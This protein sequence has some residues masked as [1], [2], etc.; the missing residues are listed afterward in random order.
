[1]RRRVEMKTWVCGARTV[2]EYR[3]GDAR[4]ADVHIPAEAAAEGR[5][6]LAREAADRGRV[7]HD[8]EAIAGDRAEAVDQGHSQISVQ[9]HRGSDREDTEAPGCNIPE[10]VR[11]LALVRLAVGRRSW[12]PPLMRS[13]TG[14]TSRYRLR[15]ST[16]EP[17]PGPPLRA[18]S[19]DPGNEPSQRCLRVPA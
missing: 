5:E 16:R 19:P 13:V 4:R 12:V 8:L 10:L 15:R 18:W 1:M 9:G 17:V 11:R 2:G 3:Q 6:I 14:P 7:G